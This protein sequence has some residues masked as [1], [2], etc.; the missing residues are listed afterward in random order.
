[1]K[2]VWTQSKESCP[3]YLQQGGEVTE[4]VVRTGRVRVGDDGREG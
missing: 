2:W 1:M 4:E 3:S